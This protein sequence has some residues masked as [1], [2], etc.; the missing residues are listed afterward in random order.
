MVSWKSF[1][2]LLYISSC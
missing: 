1:I 2:F